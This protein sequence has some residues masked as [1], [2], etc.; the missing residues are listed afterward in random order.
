M[1]VSF[2]AWDR[3]AVQCSDASRCVTG[4]DIDVGRYMR[5][6]VRCDDRP[7]RH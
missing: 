6:L 7:G 5:N 1:A 2:H 4:T 3:D